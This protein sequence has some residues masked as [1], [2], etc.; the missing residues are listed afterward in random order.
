MDANVGFQIEILPQTVA[1]I[2]YR[3]LTLDLE[4]GSNYDMDDDRVHIG[5][6]LTF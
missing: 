3:H 5:I 2:G 4:D 6:R 1:F